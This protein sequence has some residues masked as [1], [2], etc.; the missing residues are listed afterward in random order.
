[1]R[2]KFVV[3]FLGIFSAPLCAQQLSLS[4]DNAG[5]TTG[6]SANDSEIVATP[7]R[8]WH[9][10]TFTPG[11][12]LRHLGLD[13]R[14]RSDG[15]HG[16]ISQST[17]AKVFFA[18]SI[19]SPQFPIP[20]TRWAVSLR[21]YNSFV[22]L[23]HQFYSSNTVDPN[24]GA[25]TGERIDVGTEVSGRYSYIVP[26]LHYNMPTTGGGT[27]SVALGIGLWNASLSGDII[28]TPANHPYEGLPADSIHIDTSDTLAYLFSMSY[29][30]GQ[31]TYEMTVGGT[32]FS[33]GNY[34]YQLEEITMVAGRNFSL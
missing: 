5:Q 13:V 34:D 26:S 1:M 15:F 9:G 7:T 30:G 20:D 12:G 31:W 8:W 33:D 17:A 3:T 16:N 25:E 14:R 4:A 18:F 32:E 23:D 10:I 28:L 21:M 11:V 24:T 22:S 6:E 2:Y 19:S 29:S 27:F